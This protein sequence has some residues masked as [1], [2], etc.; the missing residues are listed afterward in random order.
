MDEERPARAQGCSEGGES[1][2]QVRHV[3]EHIHGSDEVKSVGCQWFAVEVEKR[4]AN[5][6]PLE[7]PASVIVQ[8]RVDFCQ[9]NG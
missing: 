2:A 3:F 5:A 9:G 1:R 4:G 6:A 7:A 8:A